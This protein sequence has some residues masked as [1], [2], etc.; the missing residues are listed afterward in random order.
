[1]ECACHL[2]Y[3]DGKGMGQDI[4]LPPIAWGWE[5]KGAGTSACHL[6]HGDGKGRGQ[7]IMPA[8]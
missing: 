8:T 3:G 1:M 4:C 7:G 2:I 6:L 5:G